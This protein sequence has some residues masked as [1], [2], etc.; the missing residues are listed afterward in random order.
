MWKRNAFLAI[1]GIEILLLGWL[2][3]AVLPGALLMYRHSR[4]ALLVPNQ[5]LVD[6]GV[7]CVWALILLGVAATWKSPPGSL[8]RDLFGWQTLLLGAVGVGVGF[9]G[10][11]LPIVNVAGPIK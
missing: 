9:W 11:L 2:R 4:G 7:A 1:V 8:R 3:V 5:F 10:S 6:A